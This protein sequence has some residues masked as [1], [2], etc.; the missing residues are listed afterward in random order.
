MAVLRTVDER[1]VATL[2]LDDG[3]VN[4]FDPAFFAALDDALDACADDA[5]VVVAGRAGVF[6]AGL[7]RTLL[8]TGDDD[9]IG[10]LLV[11]FGRSMLRLWTEPRPVVAAATGHAVAGGTILAMACDHAVAAEDGYW[12]LTETRIDFEV[13]YFGLA[14]ARANVR[15]DRLEDLLLPGERVTA[16]QAVAAGFAD[17]VVAADQVLPDAQERARELAQLPARAYA[18]TKHRLR[19]DA[20][21]S[22]LAGLADD[23]SALTAH[24]A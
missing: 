4:A 21:R 17:V 13:P 9:A 24:L 3:K 22:A 19:G 18:G 10:D 5:A 1:G 11:A 20:A 15:A 6:S 2:T 8:G 16:E 23:I 7:D 12:G 14:L